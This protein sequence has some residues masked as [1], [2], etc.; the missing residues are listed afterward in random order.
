MLRVVF[1][2]AAGAAVLIAGTLAGSA[3]AMQPAQAATYQCG[4]N[5]ITGGWQC[6]GY[7]K[8]ETTLWAPGGYVGGLLVEGTRVTVTC[9]YH[10]DQFQGDATDGYW[11]HTTWDSWYGTKVG[12]VQDSDID[13]GGHTPNQ[14]GIPEC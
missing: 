5:T 4:T 13:F 11:D 1:G 3:I 2:K 9:W 8:T 7:T 12:H 10:Y 6:D 14:L